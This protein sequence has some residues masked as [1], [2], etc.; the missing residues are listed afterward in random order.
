MPYKCCVPG[1][2]SNYSAAGD[3]HVSIYRFPSDAAR[4]ELW[5]RKI[6]RA[7]LTVTKHTRICIRH[8]DERFIVRNYTFCGA[9]G[10]MKSEARPVPLLTDDSYPSIFPDLACYL[11]EKL[12]PVRKNPDQR[13][14]EIDQRDNEVLDSFNRSDTIGDYA[15]FSSRIK[16]FL[17]NSNG[18]IAEIGEQCCLVYILDF[19]APGLKV[20]IKISKDLKVCVYHRTVELSSREFSW[21]LGENCLLERWS[22]LENLLSHYR[23]ITDDHNY[24]D[25]TAILDKVCQLL[26]VLCDDDSLDRD[27]INLSCVSFCLE[28]LQLSSVS[29][30]RRRYSSD[31]LRL[32]LLLHGRSSACY[33]ILYN[34]GRLILPHTATL[35]KLTAIFDVNPGIDSLDH[36]NYI[37]LKSS[38]LTEMQRHVVLQLDEIHVNANLAFAGGAI[39]GAALNTEQ[40]LAHS[41]Q[42]FMISSLFCNEK[43][44]VALC[45]VKDLKSEDLVGML[46]KVLHLVQS[47]G[48]IVVCITADNNQM[49]AKAFK[50][51]AD[52]KPIEHGVDNP[53]FPGHLIFFMFDT[54]HIL[55]CIRNNWL[56]Q[57][58]KRQSFNYPPVSKDL[59]KFAALVN[60]SPS[61]LTNTDDISSAIESDC[62]VPET[63]KDRQTASFGCM[64][65]LYQSESN[66]IVKKAYRLTHKSLNPTSLERQQVSLVLNIFHESTVAGLFAVGS[67]DSV[68][69]ARF[70]GIILA[71]WR[72]VNVKNAKKGLRKR[73]FLSKPLYCLNDERL[74]FMEKFSEWVKE[75]GTGKGCLTSQTARA[76]IHST[77]TI[78]NV[79]KYCKTVLKVNYLLTGKLQTD[80]LERRFGEYRQLS[81]G[82]YHV[83]VQQVLEAEKKL[84]L[85]SALELSSDKLGH[86]AV[87]NIRD[88]LL[89]EVSTC[90]NTIPSELTGI[91]L[92]VL[93]SC[94]SCDEAS[95]VYISGFVV[96]KTVRLLNCHKCKDMIQMDRDLSVDDDSSDDAVEHT[97]DTSYVQFLDRGGLK[98]PSLSAVLVGYRAYCVVQILI[99]NKYE[100]TFL[101]LQKQKSVVNKLV[102]EVIL[103]DDYFQS[104][105]AEACD[106]CC[107]P[108]I[109]VMKMLVP[110]FINVLLNNYTKKHNDN[111]AARGGK[112][113]EK[114]L[115]RKLNTL[116]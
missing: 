100:N 27:S 107:K 74:D 53:H 92:E 11:S 70:T 76:L 25:A 93:D 60:N 49:N 86:I 65:D 39:T 78:V 22:Q 32:A 29:P 114:G 75:W 101:L 20:S 14:D 67:D 56:N 116:Q 73:D 102:C 103:A 84:R 61:Q 35:R 77:I 26:T 90:E 9:D 106:L 15:V 85:S 5:I 34:M 48:F 111:A 33:K 1:C 13:R 62:A 64:K 42:A 30:S 71:W 24:V 110:H 95:M 37:K 31:M 38:K 108:N 51:F 55:K 19:D 4:H 104:E 47:N 28:Q 8:F 81:G 79:F 80:N 96:H 54:V 63:S 68:Q 109:E 87:R 16:D 88:S 44:V 97:L 36:A 6:P 3:D 43:E 46:K 115:K 105:T 99:S 40:V 69:T 23:N 17:S 50:D 72:I 89:D 7:N 98:Y 112:K 82:N 2:N 12:P 58:D 18:W 59:I 94:Y 45:P 41:V 21:C 91:P 83:S 57:T 10:L 66:L 52:G 113:G